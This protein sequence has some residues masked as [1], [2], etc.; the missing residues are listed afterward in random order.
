MFYCVSLGMPSNVFM[1]AW[2]SEREST[3]ITELFPVMFWLGQHRGY[4]LWKLLSKKMK[5][6][7]CKKSFAFV[8]WFM[9]HLYACFLHLIL[10]CVTR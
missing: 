4:S 9:S 7:K 3:F 2:S 8:L 1:K 5:K 6:K 10:I